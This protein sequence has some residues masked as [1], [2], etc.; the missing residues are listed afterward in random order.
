MA[1]IFSFHHTAPPAML[2]VKPWEEA[3]RVTR[4]PRLPSRPPLP[5]TEQNKITALVLGPQPQCAL[6][7]SSVQ[8]PVFI[9]LFALALHQWHKEA[10]W[11]GV[12]SELPLLAYNTATAKMDLSHIWDLCHSAAMPC[13]YPTEGS[14]GSI[15]HP[16]GQYVGFLAHWVTMETPLGVL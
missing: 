5:N 10:P 11:L 1:L 7:T 2:E 16:Q 15:L 12:K 14:Q 13:P 3:W 4:R 6:G 9:Y 8:Q